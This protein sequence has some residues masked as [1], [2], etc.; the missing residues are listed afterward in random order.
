[1]KIKPCKKED[2]EE[3][4]I[5]GYTVFRCTNCGH[6]QMEYVSDVKMHLRESGED[7]E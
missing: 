5:D 4:F 2:I 6:G 7:Y 3:D 1:M